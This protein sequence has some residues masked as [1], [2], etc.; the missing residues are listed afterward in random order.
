[1]SIQA[2]LLPL[3]VEVALT[4]GLMLWMFMARRGDLRSGAV[5]PSKIALREPNWTTRTQQI[6]YSFSNQ[7]ELPVLFYVLT[8]LEIITRHADLVFVVLA[9]IFVYHAARPSLRAYHQQPRD[10]A[11]FDLWHRRAGADRHVGHLHGPHPARPAMT[12]AARLAAA[13]EVFGNLE[14]ERRPAAD[15]LKSWGLAHRFAGSGDRAAIA[16]LVYD[17]LRRRASSA[18]LMGADTPARDPARHAQAR[19]RARQRRDR[20]ARRRRELCARGAERRRA[21]AA[22]CRRHGGRAARMSPA[23]IRNGSIRISRAPSAM[24]ARRRARPCRRARRSIC[25]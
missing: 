2:I 9:W 3:F 8:I 17:A 6:S 5:H 25:G 24:R 19:A 21:Q 4:L 13:I 14:S 12:P 18:Y 23:I 15:A 1:M 20:Q 10:V 11:R 22:R 7:F 16:G